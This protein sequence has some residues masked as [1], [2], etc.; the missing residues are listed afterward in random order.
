MGKDKSEFSVDIDPQLYAELRLMADAEGKDLRAV[1]EA[2]LRHLVKSGG[3]AIPPAELDAH[4][5]ASVQEF[6]A[7][8]AKLAE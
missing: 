2:A 6:G 5:D 8:Y 7:L 1:I 4:L 3:A